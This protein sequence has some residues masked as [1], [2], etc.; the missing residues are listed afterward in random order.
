MREAKR[1]IS[2]TLPPLFDQPANPLFADRSS[3]QEVD[4]LE[5]IARLQTFTGSW[6]WTDDLFFLFELDPTK[7]ITDISGKQDALRALGATDKTVVLATTTSVE[8]ATAVVLAMLQLKLADQKDEWEMI[9]DKA[10]NW[11]GSQL[12]D[13]NINL[14]DVINV[15]KEALVVTV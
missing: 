7:V 14:E 4:L 15:V 6:A 5:A 13:A 10:M 3:D 8:L 12:P 2:A 11:L 9:A 1:Y